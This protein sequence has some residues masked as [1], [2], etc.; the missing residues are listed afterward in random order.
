VN[1]AI[2]SLAPM[3]KRTNSMPSLRRRLGTEFYAWFCWLDRHPLAWRWLNQR[4]ERWLYDTSESL[5]K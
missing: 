5:M 4:A 2:E 1:S 3:R